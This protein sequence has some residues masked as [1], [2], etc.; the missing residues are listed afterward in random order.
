MHWLSSLTDVIQVRG[1][2]V[3]ASYVV[4]DAVGDVAGCESS[5]GASDGRAAERSIGQGTIRCPGIRSLRRLGH[6]ANERRVRP[7]LS[8][9]HTTQ[10]ASALVGMPPSLERVLHDHRP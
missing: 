4:D 5:D 1:L 6:P 7:G 10:S 2:S 3:Q 8:C 9:A